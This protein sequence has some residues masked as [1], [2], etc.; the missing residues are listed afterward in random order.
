MEFREDFG[1]EDAARLTPCKDDKPKY[2]EIMPFQAGSDYSLSVKAAKPSLRRAESAA[3][4]GT[5]Q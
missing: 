1:A 2:A 4:H 5:R 3:F